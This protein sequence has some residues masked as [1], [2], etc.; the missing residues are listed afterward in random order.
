MTFFIGVEGYIT[1]PRKPFLLFFAMYKTLAKMPFLGGQ[2][3]YSDSMSD[4]T[5]YDELCSIFS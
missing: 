5:G 4:K 3:I 1:D 2:R